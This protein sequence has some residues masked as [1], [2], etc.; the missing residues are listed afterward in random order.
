MD[1]LTVFF[2]FIGGLIAGSFLNVC[3]VRM[4]KEESVICPSSHCVHCKK[5]IPWYDNIPLLSYLILGGRCRFCKEGIS[6]R[7]FIVESLTGI[8]FVAF[9][10]RFGFSWQLAAYGVFLGCLIVATFVD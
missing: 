5:P 8:L 7:Y 6:I 1:N 2:V 3:I 10:D 9:Y 4:P